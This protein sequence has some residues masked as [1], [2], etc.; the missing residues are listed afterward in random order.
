[1]V[2]VS[3]QAGQRAGQDHCI[4]VEQQQIAP[5]LCRCQPDV[6]AKRVI[7]AAL[8]AVRAFVAVLHDHIASAVHLFCR[9]HKRTADTQRWWDG[10]EPR[11]GSLESWRRTLARADRQ[12]HLCR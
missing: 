2:Q 11:L 5:F 1:M 7:D 3:H 8:H 6:V 12:R 10:L 4:R 9:P